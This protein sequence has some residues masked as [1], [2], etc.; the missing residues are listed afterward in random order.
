MPEITE[1]VLIA[2]ATGGGKDNAIPQF[3]WK[4]KKNNFKSER[5]GRPIYDRKEYVRIIIPGDRHTIPEREVTDKDKQRWPKQY[6]MWA[7]GQEAGVEGTPLEQWPMAD[8]AQVEMLGHWNVRTVEQLAQLDDIK[9]QRMGMGMVGLRAN[10]ALWLEQAR[11]GSGLTRIKQE[12]D[13]LKDQ[14]SVLTDQLA[15]LTARLNAMASSDAT[16]TPAASP[17]A[18]LMQ[19]MMEKL[20]AL[21]AR[22]GAPEPPKNRG[23]RPRKPKP[24]D[25]SEQFGVGE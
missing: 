3:F 22:V 2:N 25:H 15:D 19:A 20:A 7:A 21:E 16:P 14:V 24:D 9:C 1:A 10:A 4:D 17:S 18:D 6:A 23:G 8:R 11:A 5:E 12:R 13:E